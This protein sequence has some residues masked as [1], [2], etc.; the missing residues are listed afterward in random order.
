[1]TTVSSST[2]TLTERYQLAQDIA[3]AAGLLAQDYFNNRDKLIIEEKRHPQDLVSEADKAV[4]QKIRQMIAADFPNDGQIGEEFGQTKGNTGYSWVIDPIDGTAPF[5]NG[6]PGWCVSI[7]VMQGHEIVAGVIFAPVLN[8]MIVAMR[9]CGTFLNGSPVRVSDQTL[10]SG[11]LGVGAND[12][13]SPEVTA[14]MFQTLMAAGTSW[15]RYGSGALMLAWVAAGRLV[16]YVEP[17]MS[18]WDCAA[19][20]CLIKEAGG[21]T[22]AL[23]PEHE[24]MA[25][26]PV[27][28]SNALIFDEVNVVLP[29]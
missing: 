20:Y 15:V 9:G 7:A 11:L 18:I 17:L 12:R 25:P 13:I 5:L 16:G 28:G 3:R 10:Q 27:L 1:M 19:A 6:M 29:A 4:E 22:R 24:I 2:D 8:E 21:T 14:E 26:F 23:P